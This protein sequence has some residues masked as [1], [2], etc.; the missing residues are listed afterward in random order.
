MTWSDYLALLSWQ[1][2]P[3]TGQ[4]FINLSREDIQNP[5]N[6]T[7]LVSLTR[8]REY[9]LDNKNW[10]KKAEADYKYCQSK[11]YQ[12]LYPGK[13]S[14]PESFVHFFENLPV[15]TS[16]GNL[17]SPN[18]YLPITF[19]GS[20]LADELTLNWM[21]FHLPPLI[22]EKPICV[23]SGGARGIDQKAHIISVRSQ[24]PSLCFLPSGL[25]HFYPASLKSLKAGVLN[26]RGAFISCFP[27]WAEMRKPYFHVRNAFMSAYSSLTVILQAQIRSGTMLTARKALEFGIP[28]AVLPGPALSS[29]WT[30][31]LQLLY[32]GAFLIRDHL[33]LSLL[34]ESL[35][36]KTKKRLFTTRLDYADKV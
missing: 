18:H 16:L 33:D 20:R 11:N 23:V 6:L 35:R 28:L 32:D 29:R 10:W 27:P 19:V 25:D 26:N 24:N 3:L 4:D 30:G 36:I 15:F 17:P 34:I 13:K 22:K 14:Y 1:N 21:D 12:L 2:C 31:N 7:S 9:M 8:T 5:E